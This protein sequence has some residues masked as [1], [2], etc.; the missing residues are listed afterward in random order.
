[1][2][3]KNLKLLS[4]VLCG[5]VLGTN[6]H[7]NYL[8]PQNFNALYEMAAKGNISSINNAK[9]RGLN[10]DSLNS[11]GDTGLCVAAKRHDKK[12]F[13]T[14]LQTGANPSHYCTWNIVG[15]RE[16][17]QSAVKTPTKNINTAV[18]VEKPKTG[19]S[20]KTKALIGTGIVAAGAGTA[21]ALSGGGSSYDP[22]CVHGYYNKQDVCVCHKGYAG[23]KCNT[24]DTG[25]DF[26]GTNKCHLP[27][28]CVNGEQKG[29]K[30]VC[31]IGYGGTLCD[32][33]AEGYGRDN[34]GKC[35]RKTSNKV[36]GN[37][38]NDNYNDALVTYVE[39]NEYTDVYGM[40]YDSAKT[41]HDYKLEREKLAN[42]HS[43]PTTMKTII[44][45]ME[46]GEEQEKEIEYLTVNA[47]RTIEI[48]NIN[49]DS[50]VYGLYSNNAQ[51]IY[52]NY[53]EINGGGYITS[54]VPTKYGGFTS[55]ILS[56]TIDIV[57]SGDGNVYG[58]FGR[59]E[60]Y[61]GDFKIEGATGGHAV[62][63]SW[64]IIDTVGNGNS[65][66]IY[67][68]STDGKIYNLAKTDSFA[69][70][71]SSI[72]V[73]VEGS[74]NAYGI[75][76]LGEIENSGNIQAFSSNGNAYGIYTEGGTIINN[77]DLSESEL[78]DSIYV[79][80]ENGTAYGIY[81]DAGKV[82]NGRYITVEGADGVT[83][84]IYNNKGTVINT[85]GIEVYSNTD[86]YGIYNKG[87][88]VENST[89]RFEIKVE[90]F[91]G[92]AYGIYSD[93]GTVINSGQIYIVSTKGDNHAFG[94][95][96]TNGAKVVNTGDFVFNIN[97]QI[98]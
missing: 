23:K 86:A 22:N 26:Y 49:N 72:K 3:V 70:L 78:E 17:I 76:G 40:F 57:S 18:K 4:L 7:A 66:G 79:E 43:H 32:I 31:N 46:D 67:N 80:T 28:A 11:D 12:A 25:Y 53:L 21:L 94:I 48:H 96:A 54:T 29:D 61:S 6:T 30:C 60:I 13:R 35:V 5:L 9:A 89:Q 56:G 39:N 74:G 41:P 20:W 2:I 85:S 98:A 45:V 92:N 82:E 63:N 64:I 62:M 47:S 37:D 95:F 71:G 91:N 83:Y 44:T 8:S 81:S 10:I 50:N 77:K 68:N 84:G 16:F 87:G 33:C 88:N 27:L 59:N 58:I 73:S 19:M 1:M 42:A 14:F 69:T 90:S 93:G 55:V 38:F 15:Y 97:E 51:K 52:N 75:Y 65:Y 34:S 36:V 24:C